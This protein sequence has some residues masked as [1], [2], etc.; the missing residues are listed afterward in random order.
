MGSDSSEYDNEKPVHKVNISTFWISRYLVTQEQWEAVMGNNPSNFKGRDLPVEEVS[1]DDA[2]KFI[3]KLNTLIK[4]GDT[5]YR[6]PTEAEWEYACRADSSTKYCFGD[7]ASKLVEYAWFNENS[8]S[9]THRVGLKLPNAW[10]LYDMH[11]NVYEWIADWYGDYSKG[12]TTDPNGPKTGSARVVRGGSWSS[13]AQLARSA[14]RSRNDPDL[15]YS[16]YGFRLAA[17]RKTR[18]GTGK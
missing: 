17:S 7:D 9:T 1:W 12:E 15:R 2:N 14:D 6:L 5:K 16:N 10:G 11:G 8:E 18:Q 4:D 3:E 13:G